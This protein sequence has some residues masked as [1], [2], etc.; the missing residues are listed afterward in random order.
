M[1]KL[2]SKGSA[3]I[4]SFANVQLDV[5][6]SVYLAGE[7]I[8]GYIVANVLQETHVHHFK[9]VLSGELSDCINHTAVH[10]IGRVSQECYRAP[11][12][13]VAAGRFYSRYNL[14]P[15]P[16]DTLVLFL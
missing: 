9:V 3:S 16:Q 4:H 8:E 12:G 6:R 2:F 7:V 5:K 10:P 1:G 14:A 11:N 13:T 15:K